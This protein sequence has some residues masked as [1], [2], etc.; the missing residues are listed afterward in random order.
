MS[1]RNEAVL[2]ALAA[3]ETTDES[4]QFQPRGAVFRRGAAQYPELK[5][6]MRRSYGTVLFDAS[7]FDDPSVCERMHSFGANDAHTAPV[8]SAIPTLIVTGE[9]DPQTHR[10]NGPIVQRT[11]KNSQL[12]D[13]PS[14][15]HIG[16]FAHAC[17]QG[18]AQAFLDAPLQRRDTGCLQAI[19]PLEFVTEVNGALGKTINPRRHRT[20]RVETPRLGETSPSYGSAG[21]CCVL[22][23]TRFVR[24]A[25]STRFR[26]ARRKGQ[27]LRRVRRRRL[28]PTGRAPHHPST[29]PS[30][31]ARDPSA[32]LVAEH[33]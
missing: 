31:C 9:F 29:R 14:A 28:P 1:T 15:G 16:M 7:I 21:I 8:E 30:S 25:A 10:S 22:A 12:V 24:R 4:L 17:T 20:R 26:P 18:L 13:V 5:A 33:R 6:R 2:N 23:Q 11:L 19:P 3:L 27:T 32:D